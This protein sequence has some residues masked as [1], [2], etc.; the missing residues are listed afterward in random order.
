[1]GLLVLYIYSVKYSNKSKTLYPKAKYNKYV[2][3]CS[4]CRLLRC[5]VWFLV[6]WLVLTEEHGE[7]G[8]SFQL[9]QPL[10]QV[11]LQQVGNQ[12]L[13]IKPALHTTCCQMI[14]STRCGTRL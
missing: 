4:I 10:S 14:M 3:S 12:Q 7:A 2:M 11:H 8:R 5:L 9:P 13:L 6:F 1:M